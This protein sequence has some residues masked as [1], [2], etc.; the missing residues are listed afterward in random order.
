MY[1]FFFLHAVLFEELLELLGEFSLI[2]T[3]FLL[4]FVFNFHDSFLDE[5][6]DRFHFFHCTKESVAGLERT[7][8]IRG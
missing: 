1:G 6:V 4:G 7:W 2:E 5:F 3:C 8:G